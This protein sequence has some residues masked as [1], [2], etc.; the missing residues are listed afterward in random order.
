M[1]TCSDDALLSDGYA[2]RVM[3][4]RSLSLTVSIGA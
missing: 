3:S 4:P 1:E 2:V